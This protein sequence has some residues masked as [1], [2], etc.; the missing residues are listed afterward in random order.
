M[1]KSDDGQHA[2]L[3]PLDTNTRKRPRVP[4]ER[5]EEITVEVVHSL[6]SFQS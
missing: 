4:N 6:L 3:S 5:S 1:A 2:V